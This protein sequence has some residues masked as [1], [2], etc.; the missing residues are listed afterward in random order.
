MVK[1]NAGSIPGVFLDGVYIGDSRVDLTDLHVVF[2]PNRKYQA[3]IASRL[4]DLPDISAGF[5]C[6][7]WPVIQAGCHQVG[8]TGSIENKVC[9]SRCCTVGNHGN[10]FVGRVGGEIFHLHIKYRGQT[11]QTLRTNAQGVDAIK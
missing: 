3:L 1:I 10:G 5:T 8:R 6:H 2:A 9:M 4:I 7:L 11:T